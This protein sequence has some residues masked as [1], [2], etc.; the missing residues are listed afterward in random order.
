MKTIAI[1]RKPARSLNQCELTH[2]E[3]EPI[4]IDLAREQHK[5]YE[6]ALRDLGCDVLSLPEDENYP[7]SVFVEDTAV[8]LPELALITRPGAVSRRGET[9]AIKDALRAYRSVRVIEDGTL[10]GGDVLVIRNRVFV[11]LSSRSNEAALKQMSNYLAD[12]G[13]IVEAVQVSG[14]LHLK[15]VATAID[16]ETVLFNPNALDV[17]C[18]D[19]FDVI[20]SK[21]PLGSNTVRI[22]ARLVV[23]KSFP[24]TN[25]KLDQMGFD[26][27]PVSISEFEKME[28]GVSCLSLV[29]EQI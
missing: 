28:A 23:S 16:E 13:Y 3:R 1:T 18:F 12:F 9:A 19:D 5:A 7:D 25:E 29:F 17:S 21:E 27:F 11:G 22:G 10:D 26:L 20:E 8:I 24:K 15:T 2:I 6:E 14:A 4:D